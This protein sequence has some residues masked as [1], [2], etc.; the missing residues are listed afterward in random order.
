MDMFRCLRCGRE[1]IV[2]QERNCPWCAV[3]RMKIAGRR[4][5]AE[6]H[7]LRA[8]LGDLQLRREKGCTESDG[9]SKLL[10]QEEK[11]FT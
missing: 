9:Q 8:Q 3:D 6:V 2:D 10:E 4:L 5:V 7:R 1:I 11:F